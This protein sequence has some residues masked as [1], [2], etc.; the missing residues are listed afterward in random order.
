[1]GIPCLL[2]KVVASRGN[3]F[4]FL[5]KNWHHKM[6]VP[7]RSYWKMSKNINEISETDLFLLDFRQIK[8]LRALC[9]SL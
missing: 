5:A 2:A 6:A 9:I 8:G 7:C 4:K 3:K 1:M